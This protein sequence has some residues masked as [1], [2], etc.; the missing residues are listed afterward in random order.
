MPCLIAPKQMDE[1]H[2]PKSVSMWKFSLL[3]VFRFW[4]WWLK[5]KNNNNKKI[6][7]LSLA[8]VLLFITICFNIESRNVTDSPGCY[9]PIWKCRAKEVRHSRI[10]WSYMVRYSF[11]SIMWLDDTENRANTSA[12]FHPYNCAC[13]QT[14]LPPPPRLPWTSESML[15]AGNISHQH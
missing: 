1:E 15:E 12:T 4:I 3:S 7:L 11:F 8:L 5:I 13:P 6:D 14:A 9:Y 2:L 10:M